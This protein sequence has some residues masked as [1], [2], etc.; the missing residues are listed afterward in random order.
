VSEEYEG[1]EIC[2]HH[3]SNELRGKYAKW[4]REWELFSEDGK[5][6]RDGRSGLELGSVSGATSVHECAA[7][8]N[9]AT[10]VASHIPVPCMQYFVIDGATQNFG[11]E[12]R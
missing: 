12:G 8:G 2:G 1:K 4:S 5:I 10:S 7:H 9:R 6:R 11:H 3:G